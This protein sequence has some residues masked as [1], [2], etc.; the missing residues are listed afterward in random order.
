MAERIEELGMQFGL[1]IEPE[2][3]NKDSNLYRQHPDWI[4]QTPGRT[5]SH[6]RYQYVLDFYNDCQDSFR[7]KNFVY[8]MGY[9]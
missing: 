6:G 3:I 1:W 7:S 2:M 8:K 4:L 5:D 9:E